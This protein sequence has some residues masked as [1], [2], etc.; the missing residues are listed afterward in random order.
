[1]RFDRPTDPFPIPASLA[2]S[3]GQRLVN[4]PVQIIMLG[5]M[6]LAYFLFKE[7]TVAGVVAAVIAFCGTWLWWSYFVPEWRYWAHSRGADPDEL[8]YLALQSKL[9]WAKGSFF[10][11]TEIKRRQR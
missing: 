9:T 7:S 1:M 6:G 4:G 11:R 8:Q 5:G 2:V 10:E 3:R